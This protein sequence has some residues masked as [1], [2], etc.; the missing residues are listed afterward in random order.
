MA[1]LPIRS[2]SELTQQIAALSSREFRLQPSMR[3]GRFFDCL[4]AFSRLAPQELSQGINL[5][6]LT[7]NLDAAQAVLRTQSPRQHFA[8]L[9]GSVA[10]YDVSAAYKSIS[11]ALDMLE[12]RAREMNDLFVNQWADTA[13]ALSKRV[14]DDYTILHDHLVAAARGMRVDSVQAAV[15][16][17]GL[18]ASS[19]TRGNHA[20]S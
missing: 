10:K 14:A 16:W 15:A 11:A 4:R 3:K 13:A 17:R 8:E 1:S 18:D 2:L 7:D 20:K 19:V 12:T 5:G 6:A 9:N